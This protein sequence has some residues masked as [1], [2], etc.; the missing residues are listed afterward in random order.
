MPCCYKEPVLKLMEEQESVQ[1]HDST[2]GH[3]Q[4][5]CLPTW[6]WCWQPTVHLDPRPLSQV[7]RPAKMPA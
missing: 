6:I 2:Q 4:Q 1:T 5:D 3:H 7:H